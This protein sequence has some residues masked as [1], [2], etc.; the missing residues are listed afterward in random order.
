MEIRS[1][2]VRYGTVVAV[3]SLD[4]AADRGEVVALLGPN[5]A[6]KTSTVEAAEGYRSPAR[7]EVRVLGYDPVADR[8]SLSPHI[9]VMLQRGGVYPGM[10]PREALRLFA[11]Y[12]AAPE[13]PEH[14]LDLM[15][16]SRVARTPW[17]RLSGG[18]QQRLSLGLALIGRPQVAFLDEPTSGVDPEGRQVMRDVVAGLRDRGACVVLTSHELEEAE[19]MADRVF[20]IDRGRLV[21]SGTLDE[22]A[23]LAGHEQVRWATSPGLDTRAL[24]ERLGAPVSET[25]PGEYVAAAAGA[26]AVVAAIAGWLAEQ[27][28]PLARLRAG[29]ASLEE[30][31]LRLTQEP[32]QGSTGSR[33]KG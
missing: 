32:G 2:C 26:P 9:G 8:R 24:A 3:D 33:R 21:A 10:G 7:G 31:Y 5:G 11:C 18:E 20:V 19:R 17:R 16:L 1:L 29:R 6:G 14:L 22:L 30:V 27:G 23:A 13:D 4:L 15:G 25:R 12:Y 28:A